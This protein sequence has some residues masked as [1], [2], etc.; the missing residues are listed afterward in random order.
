[1]PSLK[2]LRDRR[3]QRVQAMRQEIDSPKGDNGDLSDEQ[4]SRVDS[5]RTEI[6]NLD[7]DIERRQAL[8]EAERR[9]AQG[10]TVAGEPD[11]AWETR[12]REFRLTTALAG[13]AGM[14][15]DD[16]PE[17]EIGQHIRQAGGEFTG[18]P[19]PVEAVADEPAPAETRALTSASAGDLIATDH[20]GQRFIDRLR[21]AVVVRGLGATVLR[22][23]TGNVDIPK[24]T[25]SAS[26]EWVAEDSSLSTSNHSF[27]S[28]GMTPKHAGALTE[29]SR[30]LLQQTSPDIEQLVRRDFRQILARALDSV[31]IE[32]GGA[33]EPTGILAHG[34]VQSVDMS[35]VSWAKVQELI[36]T[37]EDANADA[38]AFLT[39]PDVIRVLRQTDRVSA[40]H[41]FIMEGRNRLDGFPV[42]NTTNV[43]LDNSSPPAGRLIFGDFSD[44]MIGFWSELDVLTNP[45]ISPAY[46][47]GNVQIR[48]MMT[49]D[50]ALRHPESFAYGANIPV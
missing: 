37:L 30:N 48:A 44:L 22:G 6:D 33:N 40:E 14:P 20:Q 38:S 19:V 26:A 49:A 10:E 2:D 50:V 31:A 35:T 4:R 5:L 39:R 45:Y 12:R 11:R 28:V 42:A 16:G 17:R 47:K 29:L 46:E 24:L 23:L 34:S 43:P 36:G 3:E 41:G 8:D 9:T 7:K 32:G 15:V 13:A 27:A 25:G 1:M 21:E 18:T